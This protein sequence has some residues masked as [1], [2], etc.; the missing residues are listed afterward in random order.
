M[1]WLAMKRIR[2]ALLLLFFVLLAGFLRWLSADPSRPSFSRFR[3]Q[4]AVPAYDHL[5]Y[6]FLAPRP[7]EGSR[8]WVNIGKGTNGFHSYLFDI[9]EKSI[10]GELNNASPVFATKDGSRLLCVRRRSPPPDHLRQMILDLVQRLTRWRARFSG[11]PEDIETFWVVDLW[12]NSALRLGHVPQLRGAGSSFMPSPGF[13]YAYNK[14][15][16]SLQKPEF[17]V[18]DL[19]ARKL[20]AVAVDGWP[21]G[22]WDDR[23]IIVKKPNHD[24]ILYDVATGKLTNFLSAAAINGFAVRAKV[25]KLDLGTANLFPVWDGRQNVFY[26]TDTHERWLAAESYL[27]KLQRPEPVLQLVTNDFKFEWSDHFNAATTHYV[28]S[29]RDAGQASSAVF[30]RDLRTGD[31]R[32]LVP[33]DGAKQFSLPAFYGDTVIYCRSNILWQIDFTGSNCTQLF[34]PRSSA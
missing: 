8:M 19:A 1:V 29:G 28:Y 30:L 2:I 26:L 12:R 33:D 14:P 31:T 16:G 4:V 11:S 7:F 20:N 23:N 15:T 32:T 21:S 13:R 18:C 10:V 27:A 6:D 17:F 34:P 3:S 5:S 9:G 22:W 25:S 24:F